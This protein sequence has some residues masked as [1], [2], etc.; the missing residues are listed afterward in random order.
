MVTEKKEHTEKVQELF[1]RIAPV[2]DSLNQW[3][4]L[5]QH[6]IWKMMAVKWSRPNKGGRALDICCGSGDLAGIL[7]QKVGKTGKVHG[8][9]FSIEQLA[10]A[11][12]KYPTWIIEWIQGDALELPF[13]NESF[14]CVTMGYGLRNLNDIPTALKEI[15]RVLKPGSSA[16]ILDF[17]RPYDPTFSLFQDIYLNSLVVPIAQAYGYKEDYVYI[18]QSLQKFPQG[19]QQVELGYQSG[20]SHS[21]HYPIAQG[22]MGVLVLSK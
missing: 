5:G 8:L 21:V 22:M 13:S 6:H 19:R 9:D 17:H 3:L 2:Y 10:V 11:K 7:S 15:L 1:N 20:F 18:S 14:D 16:S 4:S 12:E